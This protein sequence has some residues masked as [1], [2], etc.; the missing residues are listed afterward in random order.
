M[1]TSMH[2]TI[3]ILGGLSPES[4]IAY[5]RYLTHRYTQIYGDH[6]Y[7]KILIYSVSFQPYIEWPRQGRWDL[8]AAGLS[9]AAKRLEAAGADVIVIAANTMHLVFDQVQASVR[10]PVLSLLDAVADAILEG[11]LYTVGL[12]GTRLT[13]DS[14]LYQNA[15]APE[16][17]QVLV[18]DAED[19]EFV[20]SVIYQELVAGQFL[21]RSRARF[22]SIIQKLQVRGASGVILGCTEIPL[23]VD[24]SCADIPLFDTMAIHAE[25]ALQYAV[26]SADDAGLGE[27]S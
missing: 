23:L 21:E 22:R 2:R 25:A 24:A 13:M 16:G 5:Y 4:T 17:I 18:P 11:G 1:Q 14:S 27:A 26:V 8:V 20:D 7:P 6:A 3:G 10:V 15:L 12:L 9:D 19:R